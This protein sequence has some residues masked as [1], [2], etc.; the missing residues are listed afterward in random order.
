[1][2]KKKPGP[3][4][5]EEVLLGEYRAVYRYILT[6]CRNQAP[7]YVSAYANTEELYYFTFELDGEENFTDYPAPFIMYDPPDG[8]HIVWD[9]DGNVLSET[10]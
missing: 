8:S 5:T 10:E 1:M 6:L 3:F 4:L 7:A 2:D 9:L